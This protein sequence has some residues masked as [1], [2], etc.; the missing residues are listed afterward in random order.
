[1]GHATHLMNAYSPLMESR[2]LVSL[3]GSWRSACVR[4]LRLLWQPGAVE[5]AR[6][7]KVACFLNTGQNTDTNF[8]RQTLESFYEAKLFLKFYT[9][10][11]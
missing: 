10:E 9:L 7:L 2:R 8:A 3:G 11:H 1:M 4:V 6:L 5:Q